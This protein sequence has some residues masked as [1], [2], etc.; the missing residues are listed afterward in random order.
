M[1]AINAV[2]AHRNPGSAAGLAASLNR[3][4]R[5]IAIAGTAQEVRSAVQRLR[6]PFAVVDL[7]LINKSELR[8]LCT[9][10]RSTAFVCIHRLA[11]DQMWSDALA[12]GAMDCCLAS[13]LR[14]ILMA[15]DRY[16]VLNR[17]QSAAAA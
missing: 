17:S 5:N 11:D 12:A 4:F 3:E 13:D 1:R 7:E 2:L 9:E 10:F 8:A 14:G 15:A 6:A 16:V